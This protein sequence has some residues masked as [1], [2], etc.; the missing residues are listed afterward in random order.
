MKFLKIAILFTL[1]CGCAPT[2][3]DEQLRIV[4]C[5]ERSWASDSAPKYAYLVRGDGRS[6]YIVTN[7]KFQVGDFI[8]ISVVEGV[9][10]EGR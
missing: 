1:L 6:F 5:S 10:D 2:V 9:K 7:K 4:Q 3:H 8:N